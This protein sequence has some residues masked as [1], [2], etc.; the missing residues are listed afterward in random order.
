MKESDQK[1]GDF[2]GEIYQD[3]I[4]GF[5]GVATA[6]TYNRSGVVRLLLEGQATPGQSIPEEW[7][8]LDRLDRIGS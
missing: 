1:P 2:M 4:T 5:Q 3:T 8:E 6:V 7:I